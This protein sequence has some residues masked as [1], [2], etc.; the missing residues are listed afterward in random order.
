MEDYKKFPKLR[1]DLKISKMVKKAG[2][3]YVVNDPMKASY[4]KFALEEWDVIQLF[5]GTRTLADIVLEYNK[6]NNFIEISEK[7]VEDYWNNLDDLHLL[8]KSKHEMNVMLVEKVKEMRQFQLMSKK[9]SLLYKR[10]PIVDP[11]KFFDRIIGKITF[12]WSRTFFVLSSICMA[13]GVL[14]I[15]VNW[16]KFNMGLHELFAFSSMSFSHMF[17]LWL[18]IYATIG[19]HELGHGLTCK[20]YGGEVHEI[21]FLLLFFQPCLYANVN[22]AWLFDKK[23]KQIMVTLAGGY[24]EFFVGSL[25]TFV[26]ALT[27]PGSFINVLSFQVMTICSLSTVMFNFNPLIKLDGY[28]LLSDF[29]EIPNLK[30]DSMTYLKY[31]TA[32]YIFRMPED[33]FIATK[34]ERKV[35]F[36]YGAAST[37]WMTL[38]LTGLV[39]MAKGLLVDKFHEVGML[40]TMFIAYK[41]LGGHVKSSF[42][43]L[44]KW[45]LH[46]RAILTQK[47]M[48]LGVGITVALLCILLFVPIHYKIRT[49]CVLAPEK[50]FVIRPLT[51]G[52]V[53]KFYKNDGEIIEKG[54]QI[55]KMKNS[56]INI[57]RKVASLAY[58]K[59]KR[60]LRRSIIEKP[61]SIQEVKRELNSKFIDY[62]MKTRMK[63]SLIVKYDGSLGPQVHLACK[64]Q[65]KVQGKFFKKGEEICNLYKVGRLKTL[66]E[67]PEK[68]IIYLNKDQL[69]EFK[70][71]SNPARTYKGRIH[72]VM[73]SGKSDPTNPKHKIYTAEIIIE[74]DETL[75]S[76]M[77]GVAKVYANKI[78]VYKYIVA[79]LSS[80]LRLDLFF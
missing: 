3:H 17:I 71:I 25:F 15:L 12:F 50:S 54:D 33:R 69:T 55:F 6:N 5:D 44:V 75:K 14:I 78:P 27:S 10:F 79:K 80:A 34:R 26:W 20:Y 29:V 32:R 1:E 9:G 47:P 70:L 41:I 61:E 77:K 68:D 72:S 35:Y 62:K 8:V 37:I 2:S 39:G 48:K 38:L 23:W 19:L 16:N 59:S 56:S 24:V 60:K 31:L 42:K 43:F 49:N 36:L 58:Q 76:G 45:F 21:G 74:G 28:Y 52:E 64:K 46:H 40:I 13:L 51:D 4:F 57:N 11:D 7:D 66:I 67:I 22:D 73:P 30:E 18:I 63:E 53:V 65:E